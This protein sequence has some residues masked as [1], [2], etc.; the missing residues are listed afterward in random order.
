MKLYFWW[1][2]TA[3][4]TEFCV[5]HFQRNIIYSVTYFPNAFV[6]FKDLHFIKLRNVRVSSFIVKLEEI[7]I[8]GNTIL[9]YTIKVST[10]P[11]LIN[12]SGVPGPQESGWFVTDTYSSLKL[13]PWHFNFVLNPMKHICELS[14]ATIFP[15]KCNI[16]QFYNR[17]NQTNICARAH[18]RTN[19]QN[20]VTRDKRRTR[21]EHC[22]CGQFHYKERHT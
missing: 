5:K 21:R 4:K 16:S 19:E 10:Q 13:W 17:L 11:L 1:S 2:V 15:K 22:W 3:R 14:K 7:Y 8:P 18:T 9:H 12:H 6:S 20:M